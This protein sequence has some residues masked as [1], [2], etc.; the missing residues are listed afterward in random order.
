MEQTRELVIVLAQRYDGIVHLAVYS[1]LL[2]AKLNDVP[3]EIG[4]LQQV[5]VKYGL[6]SRG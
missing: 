6:T 4:S 5:L 1:Q 2:G 3:P